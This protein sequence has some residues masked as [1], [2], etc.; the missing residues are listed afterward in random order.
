MHG[1]ANKNGNGLCCDSFSAF[2]KGFGQLD[3]FNEEGSLS[4]ARGADI[5]ENT[6]HVESEDRHFLKAAFITEDVFVE[7][8]LHD[9]MLAFVGCDL[10]L[11]LLGVRIIAVSSKCVS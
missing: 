7:N 1:R 2:H 6:H 10:Q 5:G 9:L 11:F 3:G 8:A 4:V